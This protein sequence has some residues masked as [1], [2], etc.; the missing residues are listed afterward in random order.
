MGI[1]YV[2]NN[3]SRRSSWTKL[4]WN[5]G[6]TQEHKLR[7]TSEFIR[8]HAEIDIG[9]SSW[10]S[11]CV[12]DWLESL[13]M[14]E[15]YTYAWSSDHVDERKSTRPHRFCIM[16]GENVRSFRSES[17]MGRPNGRISTKSIRTENYLEL[18]ENR[19]SSSGIFPKT[20]VIGNSSENPQRSARTKHWT[21]EFWRSNH[22]H[23]DVQWYG[24]DEERTFRTVYF[25]FQT[26][27][28]LREEILPRTQDIT[29]TWK[30]KAMVW[31]PKLPSC[32]KMASHSQPYDGTVRGNWASSVQ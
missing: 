30:W 4:H 17:K 16:L 23:V 24:M 28:E 14:D 12:C 27:Q 1:I 20:H 22:L 5:F 15:I 21:W 26:S 11:E 18:M 3:E 31:K 2:D 29:W 7:G 6:N 9:P 13:L 19:L 10:D 32:K 8:Y 25:K